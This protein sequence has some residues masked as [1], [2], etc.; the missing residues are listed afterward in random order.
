MKTYL[1]RRG[2]E[3]SAL[4]AHQYVNTEKELYTA[5]EKFSYTTYNHT[6]PHSYTHYRHHLSHG[7]LHELF[8]DFELEGSHAKG[9]CS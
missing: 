9:T 1:E 4:T 6:S 8:Q 2:I 7:K 5:V 3:F